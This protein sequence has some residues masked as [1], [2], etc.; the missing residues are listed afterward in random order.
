MTQPSWKHGE[1]KNK[2]FLFCG[3]TER[4]E[5]WNWIASGRFSE[6]FNADSQMGHS[7]V[8]TMR[9]LRMLTASSRFSG[10]PLRFIPNLSH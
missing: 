1:K 6:K 8:K 9:E 5:P 3:F 7:L 10:K 2:F 4:G